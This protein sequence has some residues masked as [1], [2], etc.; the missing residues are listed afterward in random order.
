MPLVTIADHHLR[1]FR[2]ISRPEMRHVTVTKAPHERPLSR[3]EVLLQMVTHVV[4]D[5]L[6]AAAAIESS[7]RRTRGKGD[8][9]H[10]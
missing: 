8:H 10:H 9:E 1:V 3:L 2:I 5:Q 6:F 4:Q 7:A